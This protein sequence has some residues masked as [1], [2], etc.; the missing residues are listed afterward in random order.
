MTNINLEKGG[1]IF[2]MAPTY[3]DIGHPLTE[4]TRTNKF[5]MVC[6]GNIVG[7]IFR[8]YGLAMGLCRVGHFIY[9]KTFVNIAYFIKRHPG[10]NCK[11]VK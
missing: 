11:V 3:Q 5:A 4:Q 1:Y 6:N 8:Q 10:F 9:Y 7:K 2:A